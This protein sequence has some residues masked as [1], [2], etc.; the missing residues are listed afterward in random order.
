MLCNFEIIPEEYEDAVVKCG[1]K[2]NGSYNLRENPR[3]VDMLR[4]E[5]DIDSFNCINSPNIKQVD[6]VMKLYDISK[7]RDK[8]LT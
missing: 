8:R 6:T 7:K 4:D 5:G 3:L 2:R 1:G